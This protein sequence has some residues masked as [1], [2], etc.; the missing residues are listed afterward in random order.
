MVHNCLQ[1]L[2]LIYH[3]MLTVSVPYHMQ[4]YCAAEKSVEKFLVRLPGSKELD[5]EKYEHPKLEI[6]LRVGLP[7]LSFPNSSLTTGTLCSSHISVKQ[8]RL[9]KGRVLSGLY[10]P[11]KKSCLWE[12]LFCL[13]AHFLNRLQSWL[14]EQPLGYKRSRWEGAFRFVLFGVFVCFMA[15][16]IESFRCLAGLS[17]FLMMAGKKKSQ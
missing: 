15:K 3:F 11:L 2:I 9:L 10:F 5:W 1:Q 17:E 4:P 14:F 8:R 6:C 16:C 13:N 12:N 7:L